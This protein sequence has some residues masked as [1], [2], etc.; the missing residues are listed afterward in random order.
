MRF[1]LLVGLVF[2]YPL[3]SQSSCQWLLQN[4]DR[5]G[6]F[7]VESTLNEQ[8]WQTLL[9]LTKINHQFENQDALRIDLQGVGEHRPRDRRGMFDTIQRDQIFWV[10]ES[11]VKVSQK[12]MNTFNVH[13]FFKNQGYGNQILF[14][15]KNDQSIEVHLNLRPNLNRRFSQYYRFRVVD[16]AKSFKSLTDHFLDQPLVQE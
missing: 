6:F 5:T 12:K 15:A 11:N 13:E 2:I 8:P 9:S 14:F 16:W 7:L 3:T 4:Q 1:L 10:F